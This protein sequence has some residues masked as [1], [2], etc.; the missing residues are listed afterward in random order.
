[1]AKK[2]LQEK[3]DRLMTGLDVL[4]EAKLNPQDQL[5]YAMGRGH[6]EKAAE[7]VAGTKH[8]DL[9]AGIAGLGVSMYQAHKRMLAQSAQVEQANQTSQ[10]SKYHTQPANT[11][12]QDYDDIPVRSR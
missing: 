2:D 1:M 7:I 5:M 4:V 10:S 11:I 8:G 6:L 9:L 3:K 12:N